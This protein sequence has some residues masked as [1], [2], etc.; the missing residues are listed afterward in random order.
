MGRDLLIAGGPRDP[1]LSRLAAI[2]RSQGA[3]V[4]WIQ[5]G[6]E[7]PRLSVDPVSRDLWIE[8]KKWAVKAAFLRHD[9]FCA[10]R[11]SSHSQSLSWFTTVSGWIAL[12]PDVAVLNRGSLQQGMN[13]L[14]VLGIAAD[15]GLDI[16]ETAVSNDAETFQQFLSRGQAI[17]KPI[18][19]GGLCRQLDTALAETRTRGGRTAEPAIVQARIAGP[20]VRVYGVGDRLLAFELRSKSLDYRERQDAEIT[21]T[22]VP[23]SISAPL[24]DLMKRLNLDWCAADFKVP[25]SG[26]PVFLEVNTNPMFVAF[27]AVSDGALCGAILDRLLH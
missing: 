27:D 4:R 14:T 3:Q 12:R 20:D 9:V 1:N 25:E 26:D 7:C 23:R 19:G 13:K 8:K 17:A 16:P 18:N 24:L 11:P 6:P 22:S 5:S 10:D 21:A 15:A 2:A